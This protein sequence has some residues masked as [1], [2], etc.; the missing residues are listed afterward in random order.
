VCFVVMMTATGRRCAAAAAA[1]GAAAP[2]RRWRLSDEALRGLRVL[3]RSVSLLREGKL[4]AD[5][6]VGRC[7]AAAVAAE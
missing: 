5:D 2:P 3:R 6:A 1:G 4:K 7:A